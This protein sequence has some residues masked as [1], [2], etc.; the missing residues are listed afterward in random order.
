[1]QKF[2]QNSFKSILIK[3]NLNLLDYANYFD[4]IIAEENRNKN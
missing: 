3:N 4:Q 1:M 2:D